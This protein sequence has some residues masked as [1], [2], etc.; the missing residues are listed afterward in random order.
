MAFRGRCI[1]K[2]YIPAKPDKYGMKIVTLNDPMTHC[3]LN[4]I[5]Y[6]GTVEKEKVESVPSYY[7]RKLAELIYGSGHNITWD[8][9]F[10][11]ITIFDKMKTD[12]N[13]T[14][15][16]TIRK[17]SAKFPLLSKTF[18]QIMKLL[19]SVTRKTRH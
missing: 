13:I 10:L 5:P 11:S 3:M 6:V 9:W 14:I 16:G 19:N 17:T 15:V 2:M 7:I 8:N 1:F 12:Y 4:A 18:H